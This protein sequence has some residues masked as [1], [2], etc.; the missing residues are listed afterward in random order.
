[1][2]KWLEK[3]EINDSITPLDAGR[4]FPATVLSLEEPWK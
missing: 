4:L 2:S 3:Q 1:V